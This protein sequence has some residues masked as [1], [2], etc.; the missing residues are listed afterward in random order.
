MT[1]ACL[2]KRFG[3]ASSTWRIFTRYCCLSH[4]ARGDQTAGP[5]EVFS[6]R[7]WMPTRVRNFAH[8]AAEGVD[9]AHQVALG[10]AADGR[11]AGHLCDEIEVERE[12]GG[13]QAH[14]RRGDRG[15][16]TSVSCADDHYVVLFREGHASF[17]STNG[18]RPV[19]P[20]A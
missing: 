4:W 20:S 10:D 3:C 7:N 19:W 5:R 8:D 1:S 14:A 16:A 6:R 9:F 13:A 2:M 17:H 12:Q 18:V 11:I 15:F